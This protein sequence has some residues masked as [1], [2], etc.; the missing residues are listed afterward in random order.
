MDSHVLANVLLY[1]LLVVTPSAT[2]ALVFAL[3]RVF[4]AVVRR[5]HGRTPPAPALPPIERLAADLRRVDRAMK[6]L[7]E[8]ASIVRRRGTQQAYDTL[9]GQ[10]CE[11]LRVPAELDALPDGL[12]R[13]LER[14]RLEL[15]LERAGLVIR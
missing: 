14:A 7:P 4:G 12:E 15:E 1:A 8:G 2:L 10:A 11:A 5:L 6:A 9:L 13:E 3:P